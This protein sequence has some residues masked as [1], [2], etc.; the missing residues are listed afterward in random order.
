MS[1]YQEIQ[2][3]REQAMEEIKLAESVKRLLKNKDF[4]KVIEDFYF[5]K[6]AMRL[7]HLLADPA[8]DSPEA[9][10]TIHAD[11]AAIANFRYFLVDLVRK[12]KQMEMELAAADEELANLDDDQ[13]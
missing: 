12:G 8:F 9:Q 5:E 13:E 7:V 3:T 1:D 10:A 4:K 11:M 6:N 2:L